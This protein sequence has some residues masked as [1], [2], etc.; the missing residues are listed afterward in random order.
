MSS[1]HRWNTREYENRTRELYRTELHKLY[2]SESWALYRI[3]PRCET[4]LDLGCGNGAMSAISRQIAPNA[5]YT[6]IDQQGPLITEA[7]KAFPFAEFKT[8]DLASY[9]KNTQKYDCVMSWS[10]IKSFKNWRNV[11][12]SMINKAN[13]FV[14]CDIRVANTEIEVFDDQVCWAEYGGRRGPITFLGYNT[15]KEGL[16]NCADQ[17]SRIELAAYQSPW[18]KFVHFKKGINP[19]TFLV[20]C[21]MH[22]KSVN[23]DKKDSPEI[24][25][26]LPGN[27]EH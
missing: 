4:I 14:I 12:A 10:V 26:L 9:I 1:N 25:E 19:D 3:L 13:K 8:E 17:V 18:G 16:I 5:K 27:L 2:P 24:F 21:V 6:G 23:E 7:K 11:I 15:F 22:K 20:I